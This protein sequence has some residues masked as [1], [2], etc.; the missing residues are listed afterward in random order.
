M[1]GYIDGDG[2]ISVAQI[3]KPSGVADLVLHIAASVYDTEGIETIHK[4]FGGRINDMCE[5]R[6]RQYAVTLSP[7]KIKEIFE[8]IHPSMIVKKDQAELILKCAAMG[9]LRDGEAI[10]AALKHLKAH[11]H[12]L[13]ETKP[14]VHALFQT[15][16]DLPQYVRDYAGVGA[17]AWTTRRAMRQSDT[18]TDVAV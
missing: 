18:R 3:R 7:S 8:E 13:S 5:G 12:R 16:R 9:H 10:K 14:D 4:A 2:C 17:K 11:P 6:V 1:A 15:I